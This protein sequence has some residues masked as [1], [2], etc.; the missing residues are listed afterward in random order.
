MQAE[1]IIRQ[2]S[3]VEFKEAFIKGLVKGV[4]NKKDCCDLGVEQTVSIFG[5]S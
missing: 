2:S 1:S 5:G 3:F 4:R